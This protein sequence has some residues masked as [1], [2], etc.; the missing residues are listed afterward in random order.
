MAAKK[1]ASSSLRIGADDL[2][3]AGKGL[4]RLLIV[5]DSMVARVGSGTK[6]K[7]Q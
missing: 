2:A 6:M 7:Y 3:A 4:D 1:A 5:F